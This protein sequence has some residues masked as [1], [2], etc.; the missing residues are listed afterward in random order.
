MS[1][2]RKPHDAPVPDFFVKIPED[3]VHQFF[4]SGEN[5]LEAGDVVSVGSFWES[6]GMKGRVVSAFLN[7]DEEASTSEQQINADVRELR[8]ELDASNI[9]VSTILAEIEGRR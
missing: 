8:A 5:L 6:A 9:R 7:A 1:K 3:Y 2:V 4:R